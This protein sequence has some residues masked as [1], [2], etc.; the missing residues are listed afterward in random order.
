MNRWENIQLTH[1][2]RLVPRAYFLSYD[3]VVQTRTLARETSNLFLPSSGQWN[4]H[5]LDHPLQVPEASTSEPMA[6]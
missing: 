2:N 3:S 1:E 5:S 6:D 4:F